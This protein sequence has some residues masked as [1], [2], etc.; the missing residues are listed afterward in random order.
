M[1]KL[2]V[3]APILLLV[4][5]RAN[6]AYDPEDNLKAYIQLGGKFDSNVFRLPADIN[7]N[8]S[9]AKGSRY[10]IT[11]TPELGVQYNQSISRQSFELKSSISSPKH[12]NFSDLDYLGWNASGLW[13]WMIGNAFYG[14]IKYSDSK[15][16]SSFEDVSESTNNSAAVVTDLIRSKVTSVSANYLIGHNIQ[17]TAAVDKND[18]THSSISTLDMSKTNGT[19]AIVYVADQGSSFQ[20]YS[21]YTD[22]TYKNDLNPIITAT[23]RGLSTQENGISAKWVYS[24]K[25]QFNT[26]LGQVDTH[27]D[28]SQ[29]VPKTYVGNFS[30]N[31]APD[32]KVKIKAN[33]GKTVESGINGQGRN[34]LLT[35]SLRTDVLVS[36]KINYYFSANYSRRDYDSATNQN[37]QQDRDGSLQFGLNYSPLRNIDVSAFSVV[38]KR[39]VRNAAY[40]AGFEA[41]ILGLSTR[42]WF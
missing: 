25:I 39:G 5:G 26:S 8:A 14:E 17:I 27:F 22:Y 37:N 42:V 38:S 23:M 2:A 30:V 41:A 13:K 20:L 15:T 29:V 12:K 36:P 21:G 32:S 40:P 6:A 7:N 16:L 24:Q 3:I 19:V 18:A 9:Q 35:Y 28:S 34:V 4:A 1:K 33:S 11:V 10:D 31:Y